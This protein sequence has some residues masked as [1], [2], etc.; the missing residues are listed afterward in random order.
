MIILIGLILMAP[1][2]AYSL[3]CLWRD[4]RE[5]DTEFKRRE[6]QARYMRERHLNR[7]LR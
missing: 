2:W 3:T 1:F 6:K 7:G 5:A 4:H